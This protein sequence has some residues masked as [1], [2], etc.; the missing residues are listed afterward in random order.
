MFDDQ[1][2]EQ[3][4]HSPDFWKELGVEADGSEPRSQLCHPPTSGVALNKFLKLSEPRL[5][6]LLNG[7]NTSSASGHEVREG[8]WTMERAVTFAAWHSHPEPSAQ[9]EGSKDETPSSLP[10]VPETRLLPPLHTA[11]GRIIW[12]GKYEYHA[13]PQFLALKS[14]STNSLLVNEYLIIGET[15]RDQV[16]VELA[17]PSSCSRL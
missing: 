17:F 3:Q 7:N 8:N 15:D 11:A 14:S 1:T 10:S 6:H 2:L 5:S 16:S 13:H 12:K 4:G 9:Q